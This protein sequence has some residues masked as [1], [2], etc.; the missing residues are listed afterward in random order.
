M[1]KLLIGALLLVA[2]LG[3]SQTSRKIPST[4]TDNTWTGNN[5]F[6][7]TVTVP[8]PVNATDAAQ[9]SQVDAKA[10]DANVVHTSGDESIAG[11]KT[12]SGTTTLSGPGA[13]TNTFRLNNGIVCANATSDKLLLD[14]SGYVTCGTDQ[15]SA[16]AVT[17][18]ITFPVGDDFGSALVDTLD[19]PVVWRNHYGATVTIDAIYCETDTG[20]STINLTRND[21]TPAAISA[22]NLICSTSGVVSTTFNYG[23]NVI[24]DTYGIGFT[25]VTAATSGT[26]HKVLVTIKAH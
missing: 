13:L 23:E 22:S 24:N 4:S 10:T 20:T 19:Y 9:K 1:R 7:G 12:L 3:W 11:N 17:K 8:T 6:Q 25:M 5:T 21:G 2:S 14:A 15:T 18:N 26:P 16:S